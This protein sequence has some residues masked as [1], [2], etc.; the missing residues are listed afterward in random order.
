[1]LHPGLLGGSHLLH[2]FPLSASG[3]DWKKKEK[4]IHFYLHGLDK[5]RETT[6]HVF[7]C[8][9]RVQLSEHRFLV[10]MKKIHPIFKY[11][12]G[13][14]LKRG[15]WLDQLKCLQINIW[16][17]KKKS[18]RMTVVRKYS[19]PVTEGIYNCSNQE[20]NGR[21]I[22][23]LGSFY[24]AILPANHPIYIT[25]KKYYSCPTAAILLFQ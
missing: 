8:I 25:E 9:G 2:S 5:S 15:G 6:Q 23:L 18:F 3:K 12:G 17:K 4:R 1:M 16:L 13:V 11:L 20:I 14:E 19:P 22:V 21:A 10:Q 7:A 24:W